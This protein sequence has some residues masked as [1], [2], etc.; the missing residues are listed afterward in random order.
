V[1]DVDGDGFDD[2]L[3]GSRYRPCLF[4]GPLAG[5]MTESDAEA[6]YSSLYDDRVGPAV[7]SADLSGDGLPDVFLGASGARNDAGLVSVFYG[8]A[9]GELVVE[10]DS[11]AVLEGDNSQDYAGYDVT[12]PDL[13][14]DGIVDLFVGSPGRD[15][16]F[17]VHGPVSGFY[18]LGNLFRDEEDPG[19]ADAI[20]IGEGG[21]NASV[22]TGMSLASSDMDGDGAE[23]TILGAPYEATGGTAA[24][25]AYIVLGDLW[26]TVYLSDADV[27]VVGGAA[28]DHLSVVTT[29]DLDGDGAFDLVVGAWGGTEEEGGTTSGAVYVLHG[30]LSGVFEAST[31]GTRFVRETV[32]DS[33]GA[34]V[35]VATPVDGS[36]DVAML[37]GAPSC[38]RVAS[39]GG[40]AYLFE[41]GGL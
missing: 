39:F 1:E 19:D 40:C 31:A 32:G 7:G 37:V 24:G 15:A 20:V 14:A 22:W 21:R 2:V 30:P 33:A 5:A 34:S 10:T 26:G 28:S 35:A 13:D 9:T 3:L 27:K 12:A 4:L 8:A 16:A 11:E 17:A 25:A 23:D 6:C 29:S 36:Y 38:S 18:Q 41:W